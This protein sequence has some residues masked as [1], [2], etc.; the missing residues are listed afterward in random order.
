MH[1]A[2]RTCVA[3]LVC[4]V[5]TGLSLCQAAC[6]GGDPTGRDDVTQAPTEL[7]P[8]ERQTVWNPGIP[9]GIPVRTT[10][11]TTV[12]ASTYGNG[13]SD[14]T[15]TIQA[16]L[17]G[18]P[19]GQVVALSAG[20]FQ[21]TAPLQ[22][23]KG[24]VLRGEGPTQ[25]R[26]R[27]PIGTNS[28]LVTLGHQWWPDFVQATYLAT[29][30]VK[31][32]YSVTLVSNPG[33]QVG[34]LVSVSQLT[35]PRISHWGSRSPSDDPSRGW[36]SRF[37]RPLGQ[38]ME[39]SSVNGNVIGFTTPFH[40]TFETVFD[41][42]LTRL[43]SYGSPVPSVTSAGLE[44]IH[45]SGGSGGQGNIWI[46]AAHSWVKNVESDLSDGPSVKL[47]G[48]FQSTV[49]DSY[50]HRSQWAYTGGGGYGLVMSKYASDNLIENN[51]VWNF[52]KV[53]VMQA[54]GGGN[55]IGYN[56]ME[57]GWNQS[58]PGWFESGLNASHMTTAHYELFEGNQAFGFDADDIW[59]GSA[60]I[61]VLRNH[62]TGF[63]RSLPPLSLTDAA[64]RVAAQIGV[65]HW[66]YSF[67]GNVLGSEGQVPSPHSG[68]AYEDIEPWSND[69]VPMWRLG[70][71]EGWGPTDPKVVSTTLRDGNY[72]YVTDSVK[73]DRTPQP[74]PNSLYLTS[75]P[76]F[77]GNKPWP[78]V[79]PT[80]A[81][82]LH[83][84]PAR[85]RFDAGAF[86][87]NEGL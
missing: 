20:E 46:H 48:A 68:F 79:D 41:A 23:T 82:K 77:F 70:R 21:I 1:R 37:N 30:A 78:W 59:G 13:S 10:V 27:M 47:E 61:S 75:K 49:R 65:G 40:I 26:L 14:A 18:C 51:I 52:N 22:I 19:A 28:N 29:D 71:G 44:D 36:F 53:M 34:E 76:A 66:W 39:V 3:V 87:R 62:L 7:L 56:Y 9:G 86:T 32:S 33:V 38:I 31:G 80:G 8:T 74:I 58:D 5:L 54:T 16:A 24:V 55:V 11:C 12:E 81:T 69:P 42:E 85:T 50:L 83:T 63:R 25:T 2:S 6:N 72:D 43:G 60:Y 67:I 57:D 45:V 4:G 73:W 35:D 17:D 64:N 15:A 84:L